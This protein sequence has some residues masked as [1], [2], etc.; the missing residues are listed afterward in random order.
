MVRRTLRVREILGSTPSTP[1]SGLIYEIQDFDYRGRSAGG[2]GHSFVVFI[3]GPGGA[4]NT[5]HVALSEQNC[6][7]PG[8]IG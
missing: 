4:Q 8:S 1:I 5:S 6:L 7:Y 3:A 2:F